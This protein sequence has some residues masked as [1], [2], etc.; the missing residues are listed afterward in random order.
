MAISIYL[1]YGT[2]AFIQHHFCSLGSGKRKTRGFLRINA[3]KF[4]FP[5][6]AEVSRR[7]LPGFPHPAF[8]EK[9]RPGNTYLPTP[10]PPLQ[11]HNTRTST[12]VYTVLLWRY[13][14]CTVPVHGAVFCFQIIMLPV[15]RYST[16]IIRPDIH[17][18][19][20]YMRTKGKGRWPCFI[21]TSH[22]R[23][24]HSTCWPRALAPLYCTVV[25]YFP[26]LCI[27]YSTSRFSYLR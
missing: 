1:L 17:T 2:P 23:I 24:P 15:Y 6:A 13:C 9:F 12:C 22:Q 19:H 27:L 8:R 26:A 25:L 7:P 18:Q 14:V 11:C 10:S 4:T 5:R 16:C 21:S 20:K 3:P